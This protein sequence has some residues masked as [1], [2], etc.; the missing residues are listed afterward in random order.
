MFSR[1][2]SFKNLKVR[3]CVCMQ[4]HLCHKQYKLIINPVV[5]LSKKK[6][7]KTFRSIVF[8]TKNNY[9]FFEI[10]NTGVLFIE[11]MKELIEVLSD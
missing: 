11:T 8:S 3:T 4:A 1:N 7:Y 6:K 2:I 10:I 9:Y 5:L